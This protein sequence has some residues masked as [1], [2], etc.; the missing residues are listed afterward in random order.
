M[1]M[2]PH[3]LHLKPGSDPRGAANAL[4]DVVNAGRNVIASVPGG[5]QIGPGAIPLAEA[6]VRWV[7]TVENQLTVLSLDLDLVDALHTSRYWRIRQLHEEPIRPVALVQA[8]I[9]RQAGWLEA[10]R[11]ELEQRI[12]RAAAAQGDPAVIDTN[13]LLEFMPPAQIDW[14]SILPASAVRLVVPLRVI[15]ELDLLKFDRRRP[16]RAD[17]ARRILPQLS[18]VV[19]AG[20]EPREV[21]E[22][23]TIEVLV[24]PA[25]RYR[26]ADGDEEVLLTCQELEQ[27]GGR[28]VTLVSADTGIRLRAQALGIRAIPMPIQYSR[29]TD[30]AGTE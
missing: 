20:G 18:A 24:G 27:F 4:A 14:R 17:R 25:P 5:T 6:Y 30:R 2:R 3:R 26:P 11:R 23:T 29:S 16:E 19:G 12:H 13:V 28:P 21:R 8:E 15:E 10:L 1:A 22:G 7:E 9:D